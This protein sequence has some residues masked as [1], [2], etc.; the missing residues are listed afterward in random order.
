[1]TPKPSTSYILSEVADLDREDIYFNG[2]LRF[3]EDEAEEYQDGLDK[4]LNTIGH[5]PGIR[6]EDKEISPPVRWW[7]YRAHIVVWDIT[8]DGKARI[9]RIRGQREGWQDEAL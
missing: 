3:G 6:P 7:V 8:I 4:F 2:I 1:M 9:L 5:D